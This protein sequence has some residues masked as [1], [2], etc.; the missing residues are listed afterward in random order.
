MTDA[1]A[2]PPVFPGDLVQITT[3]QRQG[4]IVVVEDVRAGRIAGYMPTATT[5]NEPAI[6][7]PARL[8]DGEFVV[9][10]VAAVM[11]PT[12]QKARAAAIETAKI[13]AAEAAAKAPPLVEAEA[14]DDPDDLTP[15][16]D[17][18]FRFNGRTTG[19]GQKFARRVRSDSPY[20]AVDKVSAALPIMDHGGAICVLGFTVDEVRT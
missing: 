10:G 2:P 6:D 13:V 12:L 16:F 4:A 19:S 5:K 15:R 3:P 9:V 20:E 18:E 11:T 17:V 14:E 7:V 8:R 1:K